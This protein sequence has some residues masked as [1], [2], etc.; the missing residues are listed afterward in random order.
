MCVKHQQSFSTITEISFIE[1][2]TSEKIKGKLYHIKLYQVHPSIDWNLTTL[3]AIV[4]DG[5]GRL[6]K[7][8]TNIGR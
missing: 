8:T 5:K 1:G 6:P 2:G 4:T 3:V 7:Y